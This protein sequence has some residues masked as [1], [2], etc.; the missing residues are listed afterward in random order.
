MPER[1]CL[2]T[3][4]EAPEPLAQVVGVRGEGLAQPS[5]GEATNGP[6]GGVEQAG[7][8]AE[9]LLGGGAF[10]RHRVDV[11]IEAIGRRR[12]AD[13]CVDVGPGRT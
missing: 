3:G 1:R 10:D 8:R 2:L 12:V 9:S 11:G 5:R 4:H 7:L 6:R 13:S